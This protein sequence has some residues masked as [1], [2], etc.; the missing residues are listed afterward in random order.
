MVLYNVNNVCISVCKLLF[1]KGIFK[2]TFKVN[3]VN[4]GIL[5]MVGHV[6]APSLARF[7]VTSKGSRMNTY[8]KKHKWNKTAPAALH[9]QDLYDPLT[10]VTFM[11]VKYMPAGD[12]VFFA[13]MPRGTRN[14]RSVGTFPTRAKAM[15][16]AR[17]WW[18]GHEP[19][20]RALWLS[21]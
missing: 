2:L 8:W 21:A 19:M 17:K 20:H 12:W 5:P 6:N 7:N 11:M 3:A 18:K 16:A 4:L 13:C 14:Q 15:V 1:Y 10:G 9:G